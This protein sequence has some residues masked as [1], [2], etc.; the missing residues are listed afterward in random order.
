MKRIWVWIMALLLV[1][2]TLHLVAQSCDRIRVQGKYDRQH[3]SLILMDWAFMHRT[4]HL[5]FDYDETEITGRYF[6]GRI[7][8][9]SLGEGLT[10][11]LQDTDLGFRI[12]EDCHVEISR[13]LRT[14]AA[15]PEVSTATPVR[16][17]FTLKGIVR[18]KVTGETLPYARLVLP[19]AQLGTTTNVDGYFTL[20]HVPSDTLL[21]QVSYLGYRTLRFRL[22]PE[23]DMEELTLE[24]ETAER[25]LT[26][27]VIEA[28]KEDQL[29]KAATGVSKI[30]LNPATIAVLPSL[31]EKDIFRSL[32]LL[33]GVSGSS[34][35]SSG[36][37][38]RGGT[39]D[40][41]LVVFDGFTVYHVDH[42]FGYFSAFNPVAVK[43][44]QMYKGGFD[45]KYGGR[46]SSVLELTGKDGN[47]ENFNIGAG[48]SLLAV[49]G[50]LESPFAKGKGSVMVAGRRSFQSGFYNSIFDK[51]V[52]EPTG[53]GGGPGGGG[54]P[55]SQVQ[56]QPNTFF[57]DLNAKLTYRPSQ[58]DI[59]ALSFYNGEDNL[60]NSRNLDQ[61]QL[62][63]PFGGGS[64]GET[65]EFRSETTDL[66][67][68]GNWGASA[69]W[70]RRWSQAFYSNAIASFSN[71]YNLRDRS[72]YTYFKLNEEEREINQG[73]AEDNRVLDYSL[74]WDNEWKVTDK[75]QLD[76]GLNSTYNDIDYSYIQNDT[77][78]V[79]ERHN[80]GLQSALYVQGQY[81]FSDK[82]V[83]KGGLRATHYGVTD[84]VYWEPRASFSFQLTPRLRLK[85]AWGHY[86]QFAT[87]VLREDI[88][89]G[90]RE[91][92]VLADG[93]VNPVAASQH[94]IF[95][96]SYETRG[97]LFDVE[98]Y[99][100]PMQ[101]ISE[102]TSRF[103]Y[104]F[105]P[106]T[107]PTVS[108]EEQF[109]QGTGLSR[110]IEFLIQ[111]KIG[112][113]VGWLGYTLSRVEHEYEVFGDEP[114][115]AAH[116]QTHEIK[117]VNSYTWR[118][119]TFS[120]NFIY[121]TGKPYT[122]PNGY[123]TLTL[124]GGNEQSFLSISDKNA[125][126]RPDY[127][128]ID[129]SA[130]YRLNLGVGKADVGLSIFN[131][132]NRKNVWYYEYDVVDS[133]L[134]ETQ[135]LLQK[136]TPSVFFNWSLR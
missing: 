17:D 83:L 106:G 33:P 108:Y 129:L 131:L 8:L 11:L 116:D 134:V 124:P 87:R 69:R 6:T 96:G 128:R 121:A 25:T 77:I 16:S 9:V 105:R 49:S 104:S 97:W 18:D 60:D 100:K 114:F 132:Y 120:G 61:S 115:A 32:Q 1:G 130:T 90:S 13:A 113:Y 136:F 71:Y 118:Q 10:L 86:H 35:N 59:L 51:F 117:L 81:L 15:I 24:L 99:Y 68:W 30:S 94:Y 62:Q 36:L 107:E 80:Q 93:D 21:L 103:T 52:Q 110:G 78:T 76:F 28:E 109:Y 65:P 102:Y 23:L 127:H 111:K 39:P 79:L 14:A 5:D 45:P 85:G 42:L 63:G 37:Y 22:R 55:F 72:N 34:D 2:N 31:G 20:Y 91:F 89:Q 40:Q 53:P 27:V 46:L 126:R 47:R 88:Q 70:S 135:V 74:R 101:G 12:T 44:V 3:I 92:W 19:A 64:G 4:A 122:R 56:T 95:G 48:I 26:T 73:Y 84:Q 66:T 7:P 119:W 125:Y 38:V 82:L 123:Y 58:R 98:A 50:Y 29:I 54:G 41:N 75:L 112:Q 67:R 133:E 43:D 57:Y